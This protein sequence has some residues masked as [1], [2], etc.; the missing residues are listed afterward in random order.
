MKGLLFV[1]SGDCY[2]DAHI[3]WATGGHGGSRPLSRRLVWD[4]R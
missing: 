1:R 3:P 2:L 4:L